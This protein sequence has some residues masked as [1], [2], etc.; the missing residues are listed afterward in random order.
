MWPQDDLN[1]TEKYICPMECK[2]GPTFENKACHPAR[3]SLMASIVAT[4]SVDAHKKI[5]E[6]PPPDNLG[7]RVWSWSLT[8]IVSSIEPKWYS[9][10]PKMVKPMHNN[11]CSTE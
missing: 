1:E 11:T 9:L 5:A 7:C 2:A 6:W 3:D 4:E 10:E 8:R